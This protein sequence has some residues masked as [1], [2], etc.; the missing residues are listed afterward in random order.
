MKIARGAL[1]TET[2]RF[3]QK[4]KGYEKWGRGGREERTSFD[5]FLFALLGD[6]L[7]EKFDAGLGRTRE[8]IFP[9]REQGFRYV[10]VSNQSQCQMLWS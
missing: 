3:W 10:L 1:R 2:Q 9:D 7:I 5:G 4:E 8:Y 6:H